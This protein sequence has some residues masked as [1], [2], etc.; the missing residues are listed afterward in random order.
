MRI[1]YFLMQTRWKRKVK[2][3]REQQRQNKFASKEREKKRR[4]ALNFQD[5]GKHTILTHKEKRKS[6]RGKKRDLPDLSLFIFSMGIQYLNLAITSTDIYL[7]IIIQFSMICAEPEKVTTYP[8]RRPN[9]N[10]RTANMHARKRKN[11]AHKKT[12]QL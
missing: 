2:M 8:I 1:A 3:R 12:T 11:Q 6:I 4:S 10:P 9:K 7:Y 5:F